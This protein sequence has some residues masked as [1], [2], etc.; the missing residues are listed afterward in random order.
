MKFVKLLMLITF[1]FMSV[2]LYSLTGRAEDAGQGYGYASTECQAP[3]SRPDGTVGCGEPIPT[4]VPSPE[5]SSS[6]PDSSNSTCLGQWWNCVKR[7]VDNP[8][9]W[10]GFGEYTQCY[11]K[12]VGCARKNMSAE[13]AENN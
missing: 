6:D 1:S 8:D 11:L 9:T 13:N 5:P 7:S 2:G 4:P 10:N 12:V 3:Y